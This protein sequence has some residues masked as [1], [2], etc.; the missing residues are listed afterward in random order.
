MLSLR[1]TPDSFPS[2]S[3]P[4][5]TDPKSVLC[6][7][8]KAGQCTKGSKCKFSHDLNIERKAE[9]KDLYSD[10]RIANED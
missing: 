5:G 2:F 10:D 9:K 6:N 4:F 7:Y 1:V 8:F 3:V